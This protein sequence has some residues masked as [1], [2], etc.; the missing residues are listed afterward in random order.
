MLY[1]RRRSFARP[2]ALLLGLSAGASL[3]TPHIKAPEAT[4]RFGWRDAAETVTN[5]FVIRNTGDAPLALGVIRTSCGCTRA[6]PDRRLLPPGEETT[7]EVR[8]DL[9]GLNGP[10][11]KSVSVLSN[12]PDTPNLTLWIEGEA[13]SAVC[14]EPSSV[15][16]G[17]IDRHSPSPPVTVRLAGY[18][19]NVTVAAALSDDPAFP[20][21]IAPDGRALTLTPPQVLSPG[22]RRTLVRVT[23]SDPARPALLLSLH[24]WADDILRVAPSALTFAPGAETASIRLVVV[25]PGTAG[26]FQITRVG[27]EGGT[28][29]A[30]ALRRPD[31]S[32]HIKVAGVIPDTLTTNAALVIGTDLPSR[33]EWRLPLRREAWP[34]PAAH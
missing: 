15:S 34:A 24:A 28:G 23:L 19:T 27:I 7:L 8:L 5:R 25:R 14:L 20:V 16:F 29:T 21:E 11:R 4:C 31:G 12:D 10:Q 26:K 2:A 17:R 33:P 30:N 6:A 3:A 22:T 13:R 32:Y 18:A 9:Q 1:H